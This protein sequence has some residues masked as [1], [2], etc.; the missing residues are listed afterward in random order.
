MAVLH[1]THPLRRLFAGLTEQTFITE[2]GIGDPPLI[3]YLAE[4]LAR[5]LHVDQLYRL[6]DA[7]GRRLEEVG[8]MLMHAQGLPAG[9]RTTREVYRHIGDYT[10]FWTGVFP[11]HLERQRTGW[12]RDCFVDYTTQGKRCYYLASTYAEEPYEEESAVL[13]RLS[14]DFELCAFGLRRVRHEWEQAQGHPPTDLR[15]LIH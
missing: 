11:E 12:I 10:L 9:G 3:D 2:L 7:R 8:E 14:D 15:R 13:R 6:R 5:F 4:M 1:P